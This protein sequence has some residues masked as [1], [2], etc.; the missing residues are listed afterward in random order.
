[1]YMYAHIIYFIYFYFLFFI[2]LKNRHL[3]LKSNQKSNLKYLRKFIE[4]MKNLTSDVSKISNNIEQEM[5]KNISSIAIWKIVVEI[6][7]IK[8]VN[9]EIFK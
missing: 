6:L 5:T 9:I 4:F 3:V 7:E 2:F 8:L 1:M